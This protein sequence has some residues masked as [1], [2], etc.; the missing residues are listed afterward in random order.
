MANKALDLEQDSQNNDKVLMA[1]E[2]SIGFMCGTRVP[3]KD[4]ISAA[5]RFLLK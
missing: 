5:I 4:G 1:Y 2:E 3:D